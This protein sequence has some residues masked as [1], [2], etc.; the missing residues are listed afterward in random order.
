VLKAGGAYVPLDPFFPQDR[1]A[2]MVEDSGMTVVITHHDLREKLPTR[3]ARIVCLDTDWQEMANQPETGMTLPRPSRDSLAYVLYTSG[4]TGKPKGVEISHSALVNF[5][6]SM[7]REPGFTDVDTILAVTTLSFD[8]AALELYL[9]LITGGKLVIASREDSSD[10]ARLLERMR[11]SQCTVMQAT[12]ATWRAL[13][14]AGWKGSATLRVLCGGESLPRDLARELLPRCAELW[15]MYG[16]TETTVWSTI[17]RIA[18]ADKPIPIGRPIANTQVFILDANRSLTPP[19]VAGEL[20]IG[21]AGLARGY[22]HRAELTQ[23]RFVPSPFDDRVRL[24]RTGDLGRWL[25]DG[26]LY[27][28]GR[29]DSQ[30]KIRGFRI[31]LGEIESVLAQHRAVRQAAVIARQEGLDEKRLVAYVVAREGTAPN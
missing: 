29:V 30:V 1:L 15:N 7:K 23:Q 25:T 3:R 14:D 5:L 26:T 4:S 16:P 8:I 27:C 31:E 17:S 28:L 13:V 20:Y 2:Y 19:G 18:S 12:P 10:P 9:P 24:Y 22:L 11:D 21:G 6:L